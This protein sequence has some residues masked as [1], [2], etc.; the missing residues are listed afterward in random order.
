MDIL[1]ED[2]ELLVINKL[3]ERCLPY[4]QKKRK[5]RTLYHEASDYVK[6]QNPKK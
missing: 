5:F 1:Y 6:K 3:Q 4:L 2:K